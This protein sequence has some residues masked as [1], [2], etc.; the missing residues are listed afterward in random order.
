MQ[1][2]GQAEASTDAETATLDHHPHKN[3]AFSQGLTG[4]V[5]LPTDSVTNA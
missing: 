4:S 5:S 3:P 1:N 2:F